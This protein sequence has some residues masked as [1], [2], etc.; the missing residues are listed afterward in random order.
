MILASLVTNTILTTTNLLP[1]TTT[2]GNDTS[3][4]AG[5]KYGFHPMKTSKTPPLNKSLVYETYY[6]VI[7]PETN[8]VLHEKD[9]VSVGKLMYDIG[10]WAL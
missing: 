5:T 10:M 1:T 6:I 2:L 4:Q 7:H 3:K 8:E 9:E